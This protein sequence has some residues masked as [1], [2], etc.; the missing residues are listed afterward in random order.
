MANQHAVQ[1]Q[2]A[3]EKLLGRQCPWAP[4]ARVQEAAELLETRMADAGVEEQESFTMAMLL[5]A[6]KVGQE[7]AKIMGPAP[8]TPGTPAT[9]DLLIRRS[10]TIKMPFGTDAVHALSVDD[11]FGN[12]FFYGKT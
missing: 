2:N 12:F 6:L 5:D 7:V 10:G 1:Q 11:Y 8:Q 9:P 4:R 3:F